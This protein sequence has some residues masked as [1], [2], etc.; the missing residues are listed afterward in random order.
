MLVNGTSLGMVR[1]DSEHIIV[2]IKDGTFNDGDVVEFTVRTRPT[3]TDKVIYKKITEFNEDGKAEI[4]IDPEDTA[5]ARFG[6][7]VY[8]VQLTRNENVKTVIKTSSFEI[9]SEVTY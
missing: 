9:M 7:H 1:G 4:R 8:D 6:T 2:G 5:N 3:S